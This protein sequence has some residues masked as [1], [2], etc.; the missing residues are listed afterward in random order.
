MNR[1]QAIKQQVYDQ[2]VEIV[3]RLKTG[4]VGATPGTKKVQFTVLVGNKM[5]DVTWTWKAVYNTSAKDLI[6]LMVKELSK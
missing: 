4:Y 1:K 3:Y 5:I 6:D 2:A